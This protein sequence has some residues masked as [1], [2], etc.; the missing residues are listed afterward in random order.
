MALSSESKEFKFYVYLFAP[1]TGLG[2]LRGQELWLGHCLMPVLSTKPGTKDT[3]GK[4]L[5][6]GR[7]N[8]GPPLGPPFSGFSL[9]PFFGMCPCSLQVSPKSLC[10]C[11]YFSSWK[12]KFILKAALLF[13]LLVMPNWMG[14]IC[15]LLGWSSHRMF[16]WYVTIFFLSDQVTRYSGKDQEPS[17][18]RVLYFSFPTSF[19][20]CQQL[21]SIIQA[22][23]WI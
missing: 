20:L 10:P 12:R 7:M 6:D 23:Y 22:N 18:V 19:Q 3:L 1:S 16:L 15:C 8:A 9:L 13:A 17:A 14:P 21:C 11:V 2:H 4:S 5:W